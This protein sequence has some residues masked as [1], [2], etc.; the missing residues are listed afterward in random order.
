MIVLDTSFA[1]AL[2][3][4]RD[5]RHD[6]AA[7][8]YRASDPEFV[9]TPLILA[10]IDHLAGSRAG[11]RAQAAFRA[12]L[13]SGAYEV[14]WWPGAIGEIVALAR[15]YDDI[16][17]GLAD[18]SLVA[19]ADRVQTTTLAT[20]DERHFRAVRPTRGGSAFR[21]VPLDEPPS[22]R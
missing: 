15:R 13:D 16:G 12:D 11:A 22:G 3:D 5:E 20:F 19:L 1:Y 9:T 14:D 18:A 7:R 4:R 21:L 17:L 10:E 8:W 6:Q 2:L